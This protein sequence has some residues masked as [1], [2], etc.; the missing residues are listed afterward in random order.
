MNSPSSVVE[1]LKSRVPLFKDFPEARLKE[2]VDGSKVTTFEPNEAVIEFGEEGRFL[3]VMI[4][5]EAEASHTDD[6]GD[7]HRIAMLKAG[8]IFGEMSLMTGDRTMADIIGI[9]RCSALLIPQSLF[10]TIL[11]THPPAIRYLSKTISDRVKAGVLE[12]QGSSLSDSAFRKNEDPYGFKLAGEHPEKILVIN[13]GSSSLKFNFFDTLSE[14]RNARGSIEKI[15][16]EGTRLSAHIGDKDVTKNLSTGTHADAFKA[17]VTE[18]TGSSGV[19]K[20]ADD[21]TMVGHRVVHGGDKFSS[22]EII[23]DDVVKI[24]DDLSTLAPL[25]NPVNAAGIKEARKVFAKAIHVAVFD[26]AF[27]H[28]LPPYAYLYGLPYELFEQRK[29]RRYGFHGMSHSYVGLKAAQFLKRPFNEM[30]IISCHLGNGASMCAIDHGRSVDTS[31]GFT[32]AEGLIMGTRSGS[33]DPAVPAYLMRN[34]GMSLDDVETLINKKSGL[35]GLSGLTN[36]MRTIEAEAQKGNN[37]ALLAFKTFCYQVRKYIGAYYA[38]MGGLDVLIF[39]GGIGQGSAGVRSFASQGLGH[40]G[41]IVDEKKNQSAD[42]FKD[43]CDISA[44]NSSIKILV[45]PTNEELMIARET[46]R[47]VNRR[48]IAKII[49]TSKPSPVPIEVSAHHVHLSQEH[50]EALFGAG[51]QLTRESD[52]SQPGQ[53]ACAEKVNLVGPKGRIER[54]RVLGPVRKDTQVEIAMTEQFKLGI[55]PP[56]R[57]SG[58]IAETPGVT[59]EGTSGTVTTDKGVICAHRHIHMSPE[60][61]LKMGLADKYLVRVRVEGEREL[62]FGDVLVRVHPNFKLAM[63]IDTDEAN[64]ASITTGMIGFIDGVQSQR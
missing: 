32:P 19:L 10:S 12:E 61:A 50:V 36:D 47:A 48:Y 64:A 24:I 20:S 62:S 13:C 22:A 60:D 23:T 56:I 34:A 35:K 39:T 59:L 9:S 63:H 8:D 29:I 44:E 28:T 51:H 5:G 6:S 37:R 53:F 57:E 52:L 25:H 7:K 42:G 17:M 4:D 38:A 3:G 11:V 16:E 18:L 40:M 49:R 26:T 14:A 41:I 54:V 31:M 33:I 58:D 55:H 43:V 46:L 21:I 15:G 2:L 45:V 27:H 30:E 1:F